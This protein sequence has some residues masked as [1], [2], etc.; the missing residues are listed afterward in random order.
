MQMQLSSVKERGV[1]I[2]DTMKGIVTSRTMADR[3]SGSTEVTWHDGTRT[4][5]IWDQCNPEV[6]YLG[7]GKLF[8][9]I[10]LDA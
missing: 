9:K 3:T 1:L 2:H 6:I 7:Q 4:E 5:F 8:V 10:E